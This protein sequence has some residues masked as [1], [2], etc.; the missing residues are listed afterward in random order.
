MYD[1]G[2]AETAI[3]ALNEWVDNLQSDSHT[4]VLR[5]VEQKVEQL[6]RKIAYYQ[7]QDHKPTFT[8]ANHQQGGFWD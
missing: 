4:E 2:R 1:L 7:L 6:R 5:I 3:V 8:N